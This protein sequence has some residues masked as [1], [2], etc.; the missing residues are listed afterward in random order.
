[1]KRGAIIFLILSLVTIFL[2]ANLI[3][4]ISC[5]VRTRATCNDTYYPMNHIVMG[6]SANTNAHGQNATGVNPLYDSVLCC[7]SGSPIGNVCTVIPSNKIVGLSSLTNAHAQ[8]PDLGTYTTNICY[9]NIQCIGSIDNCGSGTASSYNFSILS[10]SATT[11]AHLSNYSGAGSYSTKICCKDIPMFIAPS[12]VITNAGWSIDTIQ[13]PYSVAMAV[14]GTNCVDGTGTGA[15]INFS[16][17]TASNSLVTSVLGNFPNGVWSTTLVGSNYYFNATAVQAQ[18]KF[19]SLSGAGV[20]YKK[21]T[22]AAKDNSN[23]G[24]GAVLTCQDYTSANFGTNN[25]AN[26]ECSLDACSVAKSDPGIDSNPPPGYTYSCSW[27][28][29]T[30]TCKFNDT[31]GGISKAIILCGNGQTLCSSNSTHLDYCYGGGYTCPAGDEV[32]SDGNGKC[33]LGE[34]CSSIE[35][36]NSNQDSCVPGATCKKGATQNSGICNSAGAVI[37]DTTC[38]SGYA[39]CLSTTTNQQ[40]CYSGGTCPAGSVA[41]TGSCA[42]ANPPT[43]PT[44]CVGANA[45]CQNHVCFDAT[46]SIGSCS[47]T[48]INTGDTC[49]DDGLLTYSWTATWSGSGTRPSNCAPTGSASIECPAQIPLPLFTPVNAIITVLAIIGIYA[50]MNFV[51]KGHKSNRRKN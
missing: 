41:A 21:L 31:Y 28:S 1:M 29:T 9:G 16:I 19:S 37:N 43:P 50:L 45:V 18:N 7:D 27:N 39:L 34:G 14:A 17:Y 42:L 22:V 24:C 40:Y 13:A 23:P 10:L 51:K 6:L 38:Q 26:S 36:N 3:S 12:C 25:N 8:T 32:L 11:N 46:I 49:A 20:G 30:S 44:T 15:L 2:S 35:C 48:Y 47:R 33:D 5:D 4:A